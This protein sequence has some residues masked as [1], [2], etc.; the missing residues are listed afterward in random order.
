VVV[1]SCPVLTATEHNPVE[2]IDPRVP[3]DDEMEEVPGEART[4]HSCRTFHRV[5]DSLE[6]GQEEVRMILMLLLASYSNQEEVLG[7][8]CS[9]ACS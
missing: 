3:L 7:E 4:V 6:V 5:F 1:S 9:V 8:D 2:R